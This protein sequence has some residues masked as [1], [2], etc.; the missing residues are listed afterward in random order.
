MT[1]DIVGVMIF[2]ILIVMVV[3]AHWYDMYRLNHPSKKM[4]ELWDKAIEW[5]IK[6][7]IKKYRNGDTGI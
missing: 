6:N 3:T 4:R 7:T 2:G 1:D 5:E